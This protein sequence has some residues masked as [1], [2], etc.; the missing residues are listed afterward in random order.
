MAGPMISIHSRGALRGSLAALVLVAATWLGGMAPALAQEEIPPPRYTAIDGNGVDLIT[1]TVMLDQAVV[2]VGPKGLGGLSYDVKLRAGSA[3]SLLDSYVSLSVDADIINERTT[4][5][6]MGATQV[7]EGTPQQGATP[8][9][10][11]TG[12]VAVVGNRIVYTGVD[13]TVAKFALVQLNYQRPWIK[14]RGRAESVTFPSG[15]VL[16][17]TYGDGVNT[18]PQVESSLGYALG[19]ILGG[20]TIDGVGANLTQGGCSGGVCSGPTF[21]NQ[22]ALGR[23]L[24][25]TSTV[26]GGQVT[27]VVTNP[28]GGQR[29]YI[30]GDKSRVLSFTNGAGTWTYSYAEAIDDTY[31]QD[32][33]LTV[34]VTDPLGN[35]RIVKSRMINQHIISDDNGLQN[36]PPTTFQY[37]DDSYRLG[38]GNLVQITWPEGNRDYYRFDDYRNVT[39]HWRIPKGASTTLPV[40]QIPGTTVARA[41]YSCHGLVCSKP[42]W[43]RDERENQT[44]FTYDNTHGGVLTVTWP[45]P[46]AN[47]VRPQ[48]R[49]TY[50]QFTARY[51][52]AGTLTAAAPVWRLTRASTC[53]TLAGETPATPTTPK[54]PAACV[55][56]A[57]EVVTSYAYEN[58]AM[59]NNVRL[60]STTT[61]AGDSSLSATTT[62]AYNARGDVISTDGPLSGAEDV[63]QTYYDASRWK[64][65]EVGPDP[66]GAGGLLHRASKTSYRADGQPSMT[67]AGVVANRSEA[68]FTDAFQVLQASETTYNAQGRAIRMVQKGLS[69]ASLVTTGVSDQ[70]YDAA[71]R[72]TCSTVRMNPAAFS[73]TPGACALTTAGADGPDRI[74]LTSYDSANRPTQVLTGYLAPAGYVSRVEKTVTYTSNGQE[75]TVADGK[76]NLTTYEY[77][78]FDRLVKVR[79]PN[80]ANGAVSA[81]GDPQTGC[82]YEEYVYDPASNRT[83]WRRRNGATTAFTYDAL[84]RA[85]NGLRG[86]VYAYDNLDRPRSATLGGG[87]STATYDALGRMKTEVTNG[88]ALS[89]QYDLAGRRTQMTWPDGFYVT[90]DYDLSDA[91]TAV[92]ENGTGPGAFTLALLTYDNL[93]RRTATNRAN[94]AQSANGYD[95]AS[96]LNSLGLDLPAGPDQGWTFDYNAAGQ[97]KAR[98]ASNS[99]YEWTG[100]L[101]A[102]S[103]AVNGLN[104]YVT[105]AGAPIAY[106]LRG[107][108][109]SDGARTY[110][111]GDLLN[112]LSGVWSG[113]IDCA[114]PPANPIASLSYEP[115]GRLWQVTAGATTTSLLYSGPNLVAEYSAAGAVVRRYVPGP[116]ADEPMV[117][118]EGAGVSDRRFLLA[119][120][121]GSIVAVVS[122]AGTNL[123]TNTYDEYGIPAAGNLG[124]FQY[125]GQAWIPELGLYH[126][127]ARAYSPTL[128]RFLQTDPIGYGDGLNWY[129]Y[130]GNDP[131][132]KVDPTGTAWVRN[133]TCTSSTGSEGEVIA[134]CSNN[135]EYIP[136]VSPDADNIPVDKLGAGPTDPQERSR[137]QTCGSA[138]YNLSINPLAETAG[139]FG[140]SGGAL[141]QNLNRAQSNV[142][143]A[144]AVVTATEIRALGGGARALG[145][146][147]GS[148]GAWFGI[149]RVLFGWEAT[150]VSAALSQYGKID[151]AYNELYA[152]ALKNK[153]AEE[154]SCNP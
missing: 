90:Y 123:A 109:K 32:G 79:Y 87:V 68:T 59:A 39:A 67:V 55:G 20:Y 24:Q 135:W 5:V 47:G 115:N 100:S 50:D 106:D 84:N 148:A 77:D 30:S 57:D 52:K 61:R 112:N 76:G 8:I 85:N 130:V 113:A 17:F 146:G 134:T 63:V 72:P 64:I 36:Q 107:N 31:T 95:A 140:Y 127:K 128:G 2:N 138:R 132:N 149:G 15:E 58:S 44:D 6:V 74:T 27:Y 120:P 22:F 4:V 131:L 10:G 153:I 73:E 81:C 143:V 40:E 65:G 86:E 33:I 96:R 35:K 46:V 121:Q 16:T 80:A 28:A 54:I 103:Y 21:A 124:R 1:G 92:R 152:E 70:A 60:V 13:G 144:G 91:V 7:F 98:I 66:D 97:V 11:S 45:A 71:G 19:M 14:P 26:G 62:Y 126:Y 139:A 75:K 110:C 142:R 101:A 23:A 49:Y 94:S 99:V 18:L 83:L 145:Q 51:Y 43:I 12:S 137:L 114:A 111:Y 108:L 3:I 93:G 48:T 105:V 37:S 9:D 129:A 116:G 34:T 118:Y 82:D 102:K 151:K 136:D 56:T 38:W 150:A 119:D 42:D 147:A 25:G 41:S 78:G 125:T 89:Y 29:T 69:G 133:F 88:K 53:Q 104:Q 154:R 122:S 141:E 117:W